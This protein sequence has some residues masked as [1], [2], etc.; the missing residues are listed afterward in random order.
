MRSAAVLNCR[1]L[2]RLEMR[3]GPEKDVH[4]RLV[5]GQSLGLRSTKLNQIKP[6]E[7][8]SNYMKLYD[9]ISNQVTKCNALRQM[10]ILV[11]ISEHRWLVHSVP[12]L[13]TH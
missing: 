8:K 4:G 11:M 12:R 3:R 2:I 13:Q 5:L 10:T 9:I 1:L 7:I 6:T